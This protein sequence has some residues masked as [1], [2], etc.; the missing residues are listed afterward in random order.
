MALHFCD[1][2]SHIKRKSKKESE[3]KNKI[4]KRIKEERPIFMHYKIVT[5]CHRNV[6]H[7]TGKGRIF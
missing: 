2:V 4:H 5:L 7:E 1:I 6:T 3:K